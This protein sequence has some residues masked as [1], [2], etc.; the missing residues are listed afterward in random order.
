MGTPRV[1]GVDVAAGPT[2]AP[3]PPGMDRFGWLVMISF[4][5]SALGADGRGDVAMLPTR[6][7]SKRNG[8]SSH[9]CSC[10]HAKHWWTSKLAQVL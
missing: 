1:G 2:F 9:F 4:S 8:S 5:F 6:R 7:C 3:P 10:C